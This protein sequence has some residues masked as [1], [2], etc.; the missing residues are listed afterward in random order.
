MHNSASF[1]SHYASKSKQC[2][3]S[4]LVREKKIDKYM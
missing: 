1:L 2:L 3:F 4:T